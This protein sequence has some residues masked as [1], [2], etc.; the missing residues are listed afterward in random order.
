MVTRPSWWQRGWPLG[1][2]S[3]VAA[4]RPPRVL[5]RETSLSPAAWARG[6]FMKRNGGGGGA[7]ARVSPG[8]DRRGSGARRSRVRLEVRVGARR[9]LALGD[10]RDDEGHEAEDEAR[11]RDGQRQLDL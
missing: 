4:G 9:R 7:A 2:S 6:G 3:S 10:G 1:S 5:Y 11:R 8:G